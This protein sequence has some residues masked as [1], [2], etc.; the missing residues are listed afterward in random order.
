VVLRAGF[1]AVL[2]T[3]LMTGPAGLPV[4]AQ[5][6]PPANDARAAAVDIAPLPFDETVDIST[7]TRE[8]DDPTRCRADLP[9]DYHFN[10]TV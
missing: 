2:L 9:T 10:R 1:L 5:A 8:D 7:A 4:A 6:T 3:S